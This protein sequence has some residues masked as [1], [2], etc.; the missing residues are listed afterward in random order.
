MPRLFIATLA[1]ILFAALPPVL[2]QAADPAPDAVPEEELVSIEGEAEEEAGPAAEADAESAEE[3]GEAEE[4]PE[5]EV[6]SI[7]AAQEA[8][9]ER[10]EE[11]SAFE[12]MMRALERGDWDQARFEGAEDSPALERYALWRK[13]RAGRGE[14]DEYIAFLDEH[15]DWPGLDLMHDRGERSIGT[16]EDPDAVVA[17]FGDKI[18]ETALGVLRLVEAHEARGEDG[19]A[20]ALAVLAWRARTLTAE[21]E[22]ALLA[23]HGE[24]LEPHHEARLDDLLW[25]DERSAALRQMGRVGEDWKK[26]AEARRALRTRAAGVDALIEAVPDALRN[27]PGL[28]WERYN[29]RIAK[30]LHETAEELLM[31]QSSTHE[32]LGR[33][34]MWSNYRRIYARGRLRDGD[35]AAAYALASRH[36][37]AEGSDFADLEWLAGFIALRFLKDPELAAWHFTR[38]GDSVETPISLGRAGYW[39]GRAYTDLGDTEKA[40]DAYAF[41]AQYQT[42]FYGLL[43]AEAAGLPM[44]PTLTGREEFPDWRQTSFARSEVLE[45]GLRM[46]EEGEMAEAERFLTHLSEALSREEAGSLGAMMIEDGRP[47]LALKIAKRVARNGIMIPAAY[48]PLHPLAERE[49]PVPAELALAIARR[50]SEFDPVVVSPVGARG[51]MQLMPGTARDMAG[52][53]EISYEADRLTEDPE[54]NAQ[55]GTAYLAGL[56]EI[57]GDAP[58]LVSVGYNAGPG[59]AVNWVGDRG[60]P[61]YPGVDVVDW[62]EMIP[63]RETRNYVMRVTESLP[64][65]RA[66]LT[67][68]VEKLEFT[69]MLHGTP[70]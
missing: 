10:P 27:H 37:L 28:A 6:A 47:H 44:D 7:E 55:L 54:Y 18:P 24:V 60:D 45:V 2:A 36:F 15:A 64:V 39:L 31:E 35:A 66:R 26:L 42:S 69:R 49:L 22:R 68:R 50:E 43:A 4:P 59:R 38:F 14:F 19:D 29:W 52:E 13:L 46:I 62:I 21:V 11:A 1:A 34:E 48:Y 9:P 33:P 61:R 17:Y 5:P 67:G 65:Y 53:L 51:L 70:N 20:A 63:F 56:I 23:R 30:G 12:K 16:G 57:F 25:R 8:P 58:V 3:T 40:R 32:A 41:G